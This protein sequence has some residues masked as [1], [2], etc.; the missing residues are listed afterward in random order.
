MQNTK[1]FDRPAKICFAAGLILLVHIWTRGFNS[2]SDIWG[3]IV[4][5]FLVLS[6]AVSIAID[7]SRRKRA[8]S[9]EN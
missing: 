7:L 2:I 1:W 9:T 4:A 8:C 6:G 5:A 3:A